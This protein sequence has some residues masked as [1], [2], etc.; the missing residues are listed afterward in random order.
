M[1]AKGSWCAG[2]RDLG[3]T[4]ARELGGA[5]VC[6]Q[7]GTTTELNLADYFRTNNMSYEPV[8]IETNTETQQKYLSNA[9][10][11]YT[12]PIRFTPT[13]TRARMGANRI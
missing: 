4:S 6:I 5:T 13:P 10:D 9:C 11:V 8:P 7:T 3:L 2:R 1:M 12:L